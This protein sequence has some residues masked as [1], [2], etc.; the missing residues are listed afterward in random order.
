MPSGLAKIGLWKMAA[1][2][3]GELPLTSVDDDSR[4]ARLLDDEYDQARDSELRKHHWNF[5]IKRASLPADVHKP[6]FGWARSFTLPAD[7]IALLPLT[8]D[9]QGASPSLSYVLEGQHILCDATAPL[10]IRYVFRETREGY[11]DP[12]F[13]DALAASLALRISHNIT[14][15]SSYMDRINALYEKAVSAARLN[16][17]IESPI[18]HLE[19]SEHEMVRLI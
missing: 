17:A 10:K 8:S 5:A 18:L 14:G 2:M 7:Y 16:D 12:L 19:P 13:A 9:G 11:F 15:K 3:L 1:N 6:A 4:I